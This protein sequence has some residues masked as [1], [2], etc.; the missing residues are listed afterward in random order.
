MTRVRLP[1][2]LGAG[3]TV[4]IVASIVSIVGGHVAATSYEGL[5]PGAAVLGTLAG[6][7]LF[8]AAVVLATDPRRRATA[9]AS[10]ALG[11]AW[12]GAS[13]AGWDGAP[14]V[15]QNVGMLLVPL[16]A[17]AALLAVSTVVSAQRMRALGFT[18]AA[19][20]GAA[21]VALWLVRDPFLDRY[22]WR[23][24]SVDAFAPFADPD[25]ART[26]TNVTLAAGVACGAAMISLC[27]R[28]L[29]A[30]ALDTR[31]QR[32]TFVPGLTVGVAFGLSNLVL[33]LEPAEDPRRHGFAVLFVA[34]A[35]ALITL[36]AGL[37]AAVTVRRRFVRAEILRLAGEG[38]T[39]RDLAQSLARAFGDPG[40]RIGYPISE[41]TIVDAEGRPAA[42]GDTS[43]RIV[44]GDE[45]V[46]IVSSSGEAIPAGLLDGGL[47]PSGR[48]ALANERLRAEQ[49]ARLRELTD[50]R[51]RIVA[52]GDAERRRLERDLHDG[53]QQRLLALSFD[54]RVA[55]AHAEAAAADDL[56]VALE[57]ALGQVQAALS[58]LRTIAHG[59][60]PAVLSTSGLTAAV[61]TLADVRPMTLRVGLDPARR[62]PLDV[63]AAAYAIVSES[64]RNTPSAPRIEID[65]EDGNLVVRVD[66][67]PW[68]GGV[69]AVE[70]R[71]GAV[72]GTIELR[73]RRLEAV[74]PVPPPG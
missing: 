10:F 60:F 5:L 21:G 74:L 48:L 29:R 13:W 49:L 72:G 14:T 38:T 59:L 46:A 67:A 66:D 12:F 9:F 51:R 45:L 54:L 30:R 52:T 33:L 50:L 73:G 61:E 15:V 65:E 68:N 16:V 1:L 4:V 23:D 2:V 25:L 69:A 47:G 32:W 22:C 55:I 39:G 43:T 6:A 17:P 26:L 35:A 41:D 53:A 7:A 70:D 37:I 20:A 27:A 11:V 71:V 40:L 19:F 3:A 44:R 62:Y 24:C 64:T 18:L 58:A 36:G 31:A 28:E 63:E 34:R 57:R 8:G 42:L 56:A